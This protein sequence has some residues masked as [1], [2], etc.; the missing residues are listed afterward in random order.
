MLREYQPSLLSQIQRPFL[1]GTFLPLAAWGETGDN[2]RQPLTPQKAAR[3]PHKTALPQ[4]GSVLLPEP[5][6]P[7]GGLQ[8][9]E[10]FHFPFVPPA[11]ITDPKLLELG[12][13]REGEA[14]GHDGEGPTLKRIKKPPRWMGGE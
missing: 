3:H 5:L 7:A 12:A 4:R 8:M 1:P 11:K 2:V 14:Q 13:P 10:E 9:V 6:I